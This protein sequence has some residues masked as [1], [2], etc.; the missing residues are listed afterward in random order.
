[1]TTMDLRVTRVLG[2]GMVAAA[3]F[4]PACGTADTAV[5]E[6]NP[7]AVISDRNV[8]HLNPPPPPPSAEEKPVDVPKVMLSGFRTVA[9]HTRV[10]LVLQPKDPKEGMTFMDLAQGERN[11]AVEVVKIDSEKRQVDIVNTG[12]SM[13]LTFADNGVAAAAAP[14]PG[15]KPAGGPPGLPGSRRA[16]LPN[17]PPVP[18]PQAGAP[19]AAPGGTSAIIIGGGNSEGSGAGGGAGPI[20]AGGNATTSSWNYNNNNSA[21]V[22]GGGAPAE[23]PMPVAGNPA[24]AQIAN[25]LLNPA[26]NYRMPTP[27]VPAPPAV[28]A[29]ELLVHAAAGGPPA[30]PGAA[31]GPP[32]P[33]Q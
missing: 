3:C 33:D 30:P 18:S 6:A 26:S 14:A 8:F 5:S 27:P 7:Y 31:E 1:M 4:R 32:A 15:Q 16:N 13:T 2:L 21:I 25:A 19:A 9:G 17:M 24:G 23:S 29:A 10:F 22:T 12:H 20:V 11:K 28:Q